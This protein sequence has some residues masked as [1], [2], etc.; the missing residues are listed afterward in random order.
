MRACLCGVLL[1]LNKA[2]WLWPLKMQLWGDLR[3]LQNTQPTNKFQWLCHES[4]SIPNKPDTPV[5]CTSITDLILL[6]SSQKGPGS[7]VNVILHKEAS[8]VF[9][10]CEAAMEA[11]DIC[12]EGVQST[13]AQSVLLGKYLAEGF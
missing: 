12:L 10:A 4:V 1:N 6:M 9:G 13:P 7:Q 8:A 2:L 5:V 11:S 3:I